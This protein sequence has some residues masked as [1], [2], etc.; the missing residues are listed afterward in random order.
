MTET[1]RISIDGV[2]YDPA[3][4]APE[5][6][7]HLANLRFVDQEI[8]RLNAQMVVAQAARVAFAQAVKSLLPAS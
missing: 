7:Q 3:Q 6:H 5:V 8:A 1:N 2:E 4:L